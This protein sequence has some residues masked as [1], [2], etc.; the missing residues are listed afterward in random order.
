MKKRGLRLFTLTP[1]GRII[2]ALTEGEK[3]FSELVKET[4]LSGR[5]LSVKLKQLLQLGVVK[6]SS[7]GYQAN[8]EK[9]RSILGGSLKEIAWIAACEIVEKHPEVLSVL[10][11][12]SV[13]KGKTSEES[14]IDL[15]VVSEKP[16]DLSDDEYK[17]SIKYGV[18][19]EITSI[20]LTE[21]LSMLHFKSSLIFGVLEGYE[22]LFDS[23][24]IAALLKVY[25]KDISKDWS[26]NKD[27]EIWVK[28]R[29]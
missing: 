21:F 20:T 8:Y 13:A 10:L 14:D 11:Y 22:V 7:E 18:V 29:K 3:S 27:E 25:M 16:L 24:G 1:E 19:L 15:L 12:G 4:G 28:L 26:Y 17:I 5:W 9:L 23:V 6:F 2:R